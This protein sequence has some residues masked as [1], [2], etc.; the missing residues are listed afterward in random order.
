MEEEPYY[1]VKDVMRLTGYSLRQVD[2]YIE[3]GTFIVLNP[4]Q[5]Q[6]RKISQASVD[7]FNEANGHRAV[8][9]L[10]MLKQEHL[11]QKQAVGD[12]AR[13]VAALRARVED[14]ERQVKRLFAELEARFRSQLGHRSRGSAPTGPADAILL[15]RFAEAHAVPI[16]RMRNLAKH[17]PTLATIIPRPYAEHKKHKWM[18]APAQMAPMLAALEEHGTIYTPCAQCP[19]K[20]PLTQ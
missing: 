4:N 3:K 15:I 19:H 5:R 20:V 2:R 11:E 14:L 7:A 12:V 17:D 13:Q 1:T 10:E 9:E 8:D 6:P 18:I 16:G